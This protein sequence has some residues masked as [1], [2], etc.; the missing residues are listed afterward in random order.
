LPITKGYKQLIAEATAK[1]KTHTVIE[2][3]AMVGNPSVLFVDLR[4]PG[5]LEAEGMVPG[6]FNAP[7]ATIE[8]W[9]DPESPFFK[10]VLGDESKQLVLYCGGGW[11]SA[12]AAATLQEMG[13][14]NVSHIDG[15]FSA[16][17]KAGAP[18]VAKPPE[19]PAPVA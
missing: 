8:F 5:E 17:K 12:L 10:P 13:L 9:V 15:G 18:V 11:R 16:W 6:A 19:K 14:T 2:A 1:I 7:R 4:A 3:Q